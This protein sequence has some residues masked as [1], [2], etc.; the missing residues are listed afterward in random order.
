MSSS[1]KPQE[2]LSYAAAGLVLGWAVYIVSYRLRAEL[3]SEP[4]EE[5]PKVDKVRD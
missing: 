1:S 3:T 5:T 2:Q 4:H